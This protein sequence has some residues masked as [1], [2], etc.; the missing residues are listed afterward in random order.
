M[1]DLRRSA[2]KRIARMQKRSKGSEALSN[3]FLKVLGYE[4]ADVASHESHTSKAL[5]AVFEPSES[6]VAKPCPLGETPEIY[7]EELPAVRPLL[8]RDVKVR[9]DSSVLW[10]AGKAVLPKRA[11]DNT[12]RYIWENGRSCSYQFGVQLYFNKEHEEHVPKAICAFAQG[13]SNWYH[14]LIEVLPTVMLAQNLSA[15]Y[16]DYPLLVPEEILAGPTF[17]ETLDLYVGNRRIIPLEKNK[18]YRISKLIFVPPAV[19]GPLNMRKWQWPT[20]SDYSH[21]IGVMKQFRT[22]TLQRLGIEYDSNG[23]K[24]IFMA[25]P[26]GARG[27]NQDDII[28]VALDRGFQIVR[29]EE[30]S[31]RQQVQMIHNADCVVGP[32]GAACANTLFMRPGTKSLVWALKEYEGACFFS[33]LAH[34]AGSQMTYCFVEADAEVPS[35]YEAYGASYKLPVDTFAHH[36]DSILS[37]PSLQDD[38]AL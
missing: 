17:R 35:T 18:Q 19:F 22:N 4:V 11:I 1:T 13:A 37:A 15:K 10:I 33:N 3:L 25:R 8:Y 12:H 36:I 28:K 31:F 5:E 34:V 6:Q 27:Y 24:H 7:T 30:F 21:N 38:P 26:S 14:W 2:L 29:P 16:D 9:S 23:A 32:T 20:P